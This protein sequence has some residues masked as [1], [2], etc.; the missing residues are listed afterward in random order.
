MPKFVSKSK[1]EQTLK[2][3]KRINLPI[4]RPLSR[5]PTSGTAQR[6][7]TTKYSS[8]ING[9]ETPHTLSPHILRHVAGITPLG[10]IK[11]FNL[12]TNCYRYDSS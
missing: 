4:N 7:G 11:V 5:Q 2:P 10:N 9:F 8:E 1:N 3:F 6:Q 12:Q